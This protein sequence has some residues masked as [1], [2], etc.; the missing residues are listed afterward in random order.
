M[1][2]SSLQN[3]TLLVGHQIVIA[4]QYA[5]DVECGALA[6]PRQGLYR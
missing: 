3:R 5:L 6:G 4:A 1:T 2:D